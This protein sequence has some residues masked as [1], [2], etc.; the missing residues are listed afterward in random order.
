MFGDVAFGPMK[1]RARVKYAFERFRLG[2][3]GIQFFGAD[4]VGG[5][6]AVE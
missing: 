6:G 3:E 2:Q 5:V 4:F 1:M